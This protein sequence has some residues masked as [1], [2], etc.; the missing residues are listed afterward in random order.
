[1]RD[2]PYSRFIKNVTDDRTAFG[3]VSKN[4]FDSKVI[5]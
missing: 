1:M 3:L 2:E 5:E 4:C